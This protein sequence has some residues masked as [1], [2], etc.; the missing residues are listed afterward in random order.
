M[1][2]KTT[3]TLP[4]DLMRYA[5][6]MVED[7]QFPS[8]DTV[9][10]ASLEHMMI[11]QDQAA[12]D[13]VLHL[14]AEELRRRLDTPIEETIAMDEDDLFDRVRARIAARERQ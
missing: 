6:K 10:A 5:E 7:G 14:N 1:N 3:V 2:V 12:V 9:L 8:V 4:E 11:R 13:E